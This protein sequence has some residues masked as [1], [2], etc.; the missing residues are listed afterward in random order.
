[1]RNAITLAPSPESH[2]SLRRSIGDDYYFKFIHERNKQQMQTTS[3]QDKVKGFLPYEAGR[4]IPIQEKVAY[5]L[6]KLEQEEQEK[7]I[8]MQQEI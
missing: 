7:K 6:N 3:F 8:K 2:R 5:Y 1:V 4:K